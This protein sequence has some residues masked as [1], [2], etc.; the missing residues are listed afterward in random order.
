MTLNYNVLIRLNKCRTF[1][2]G[3][4]PPGHFLLTQTIDLT[5]T[6]T[7]IRTLLTLT[8]TLLTLP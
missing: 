4:S 5:L 2:P 7:L 3:H 8:L 6:L 1:P